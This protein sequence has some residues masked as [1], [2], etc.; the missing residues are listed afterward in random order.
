M[1]EPVIKYLFKTQIKENFKIRKKITSIRAVFFVLFFESDWRI[2]N[3]KKR[4][5]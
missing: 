1:K 4:L 5:N 2:A 3:D